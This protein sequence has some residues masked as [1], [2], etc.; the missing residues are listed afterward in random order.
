MLYNMRILPNL[1]PC[2]GVLAARFSNLTKFECSHRRDAVTYTH[3]IFHNKCKRP[4]HAIGKISNLHLENKY[5]HLTLQKWFLLLLNKGV[6]TETKR[7]VVSKITKENPYF[8]LMGE[9]WGVSKIGASKIHNLPSSLRHWHKEREI[10]S[11]SGEQLE[12]RKFTQECAM[13]LWTYRKK[14]VSVG[15]VSM[16]SIIKIRRSWD[17]LIFM[18]GILL[19][20]GASFTNMD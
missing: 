10:F 18:L 17:R 14:P 8:T 4:R 12:H 16:I 13:R 5:H 6:V 2:C 19:L 9:L 1:S 7:K 15:S 20:T 3:D 11:P